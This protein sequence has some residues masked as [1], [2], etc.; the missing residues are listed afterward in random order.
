MTERLRRPRK[1]I[2]KRPR[3]STPCISYCVTIGASSGACPFSGL[4]LER[5]VVGELVAGDD[6]RGGM[7]AGLA[8]QAFEASRHVDDLL[9]VRVGGVHLAELGRGLEAVLVLRVESEA[10]V[11]RRV[12]AHHQRRHGLRDLVADRVRVAEH[13]G[14]VAHRRPSLDRRE[15]DDLGDVVTAVA[16]GRVP[17][18]LVAVPVV[19]VHVDVGH[20]DATG[21]EESLEQQVVLD[22]VEVGDAQAVRDGATRRTAAPGPDPDAV[23]HARSG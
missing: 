14:G 17:D 20:L 13:A 23:A 3:S 22:R 16:L 5:Q 7:D 15:R 12:S 1:S 8:T 4:S 2:F 11:E 18:H 19:E 10:R 9:H 6:H 21:V